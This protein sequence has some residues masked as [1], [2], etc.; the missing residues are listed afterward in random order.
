MS[1]DPGRLVYSRARRRGRAARPILRLAAAGALVA[2]TVALA[3]WFAAFDD[4]VDRRAALESELLRARAEADAV[5][6]ENDLLKRRIG[7]LREGTA[8]IEKAARDDLGMVRSGELIL[9]L[10][11][12]T[13]RAGAP[14]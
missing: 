11:P 6:V 13:R 2:A 4:A 14:R 3:V 10:A 8:G 9:I 7:A 1:S 5:E 12:P